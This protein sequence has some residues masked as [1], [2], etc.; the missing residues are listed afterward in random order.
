MPKIVVYNLVDDPYHGLL[1]LSDAFGREYL[2]ISNAAKDIKWVIG[3][4]R[5]ANQKWVNK[6]VDIAIPTSQS[7]RNLG[8]IVEDI[9]IEVH[10]LL[11]EKLQE[12]ANKD[13]QSIFVNIYVPHWRGGLCRTIE[14]SSRVWA[15]YPEES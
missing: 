14:W 1:H 7:D 3:H 10:W 9:N 12:L 6:F 13:G 2:E 11:E 8:I 15:F 5:K 4:S